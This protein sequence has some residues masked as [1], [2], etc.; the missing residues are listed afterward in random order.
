MPIGQIWKVLEEIKNQGL[1]RSISIRDFP[2]G[3]L[4]EL[5]NEWTIK[6]IQ[7]RVRTSL[8]V[9]T[10]LFSFSSSSFFSCMY[11]GLIDYRSS[12]TPIA[13]TWPT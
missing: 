3:P 5:S 13:P 12:I 8:T 9:W 4:E 6:L 11:V 2:A 10:V 7:N 1:A